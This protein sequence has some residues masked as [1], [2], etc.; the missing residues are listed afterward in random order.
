MLAAQAAREILLMIFKK[1]LTAFLFEER[2]CP[3]KI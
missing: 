2:P 3:V 1:V